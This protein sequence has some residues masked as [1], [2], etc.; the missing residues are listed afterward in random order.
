MAQEGRDAVRSS[1]G[2]RPLVMLLGE[3][4]RSPVASAA[5]AALMNCSACD[6]CKVGL[7]PEMDGFH[8]AWIIGAVCACCLAVYSELYEVLSECT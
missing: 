2:L 4:T 3:G 5:A 8:S 6:T 1:G 7:P